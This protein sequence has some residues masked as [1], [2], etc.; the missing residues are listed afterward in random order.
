MPSE[1][2][3][4][5]AVNV[6]IDVMDEGMSDK[7][8][9]TDTDGTVLVDRARN[10]LTTLWYVALQTL[11]CGSIT[12]LVVCGQNTLHRSLVYIY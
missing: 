4:K 5:N 10:K 6:L 8:K 1:I 3:T 11:M 2:K 7:L 9:G 12:S